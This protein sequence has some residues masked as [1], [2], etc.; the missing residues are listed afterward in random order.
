MTHFSN[1]ATRFYQLRRPL[2]RQFF[3]Q[4]L[5]A[6]HGY[7]TRF[8]DYI[9]F[10]DAGAQKMPRFRFDIGRAAAGFTSYLR[11]FVLSATREALFAARALR[12]T[13]L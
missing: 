13:P 6:R 7:T 11:H 4:G 9:D 1:T 2:S 5:R 3:A 12:A 10:T 8:D